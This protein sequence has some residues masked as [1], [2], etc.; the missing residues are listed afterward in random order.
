MVSDETF[1]Q[2]KQAYRQ[3]VAEIPTE[4]WEAIPEN[5][6]RWRKRVK[7][8]GELS[9]MID[10]REAHGAK[11]REVFRA[12]M[13]KAMQAAGKTPAVIKPSF[14]QPTPFDV[15]SV[16]PLRPQPIDS[17]QETAIGE[18]IDFLQSIVANEKPLNT[19][20]IK[21]R[22]RAELHVS[23]IGT[24]V[25]SL[26]D[27]RPQ[28]VIHEVAHVIEKRKPGVLAA[29]RD[30]L[31]KRCGDEEPVDLTTLPGGQEMIRELGRKDHF[32]RAFSGISA[33]YV[34]K[35]YMEGS[36]VPYAGYYVNAVRSAT[37]AVDATE[38]VSMGLE[39]LYTDP[40][41]FARAD[42]EYVQFLID[43]VL[44]S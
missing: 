27:A 40:I 21:A 31:K 38:V 3:L 6:E 39:K 24:F 13:H 42:P 8:A 12:G 32:D 23:P 15:I 36:A 1:E 26:P 7:L 2:A 18:A 33:Y 17:E 29:A 16:F 34:G 44:L 35:T 10:A 19:R 9:D 4:Q 20:F 5:D 28:A 30:F 11:A 25:V 22:G 41:G 43:E 37:G 14:G